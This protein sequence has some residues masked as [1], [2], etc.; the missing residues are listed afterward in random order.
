[1]LLARKEGPTIM[2]MP[3]SRKMIIPV[4]IAVILGLFSLFGPPLTLA[5]GSVLVFVA[6]ASL[7]IQ[8]FL[9]TAPT[10]T[11]SQAIAEELRPVDRS[12]EGE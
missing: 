9:W 8:F 2:W 11:L 6:I 1:M 4:W 5:T 12:R 7:T 10:L 3:C